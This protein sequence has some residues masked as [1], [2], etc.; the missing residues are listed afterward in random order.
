MT[1]QECRG[2]LIG[3][4]CKEEAQGNFEN[5]DN[6]AI[7]LILVVLWVCKSVRSIQNTYFNVCSLLLV[8]H[9]S[10]KL[11]HGNFSACSQESLWNNW[12]AGEYGA[13]MRPRG[14]R[15]HRR[16]P[17]GTSEG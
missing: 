5:D 6:A 11:S 15:V 1:A 8:N 13:S 2:G 7:L 14:S 3:G 4:N 9:A 12:K 10:I 17:Q 16:C